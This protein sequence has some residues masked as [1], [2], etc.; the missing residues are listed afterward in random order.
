MNTSES[1][2]ERRTRERREAAQSAPA[3]A[4]NF[5]LRHLTG[6]RR[7]HE[8]RF[9]TDRVSVGRGKNNH[10]SF[11]A[12]KERSVSHR[13][14]E[15]RIEDSVAILYDIGSLNGTY[16][17]GRRIRR[18]PLADGD[19]IGLGRE[20]PRL[21]FSMHSGQTHPPVRP[22]DLPQPVIGATAQESQPI[23][24]ASLA[25]TRRPLLDRRRMIG[26]GLVVGIIIVFSSGFFF[27]HK[28]L[29]RIET[30]EGDPGEVAVGSRVP[31][32]GD[33]NRK[34]S[35]TG[36]RIGHA[37]AGVPAGPRGAVIRLFGAVLDAN[38]RIADHHQVGYGVIVEP[39]SVVTTHD[40]FERIR[41]WYDRPLLDTRAD[42]A[43]LA[44][45]GGAIEFSVHVE[46]FVK[47]PRAQERADHSNVVLLYLEEGK[48]L[49]RVMTAPPTS[50]G[51]RFFP[52]HEAAQA[53][54]VRQFKDQSGGRAAAQS[55]FLIQFASAGGGPPPP[56]GMPI[57]TR[58][59]VV[60]LSL[61]ADLSGWAVSSLAIRELLEHAKQA[62][63][64][65]ITSH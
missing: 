29:D 6:D 63:P 17:N 58:S 13:H 53:L 43:I 37:P 30:L 8:E 56:A 27:V 16:V 21:R 59:D 22:G 28:L 9:C 4:F 48:R 38:Q 12:E 3:S 11:D 15:V 36:N 2:V 50:D 10:C 35:E 26:L 5:S 19:E 57:F 24:L 49:A 20:G 7:G 32:A 46:S 44:A 65:L 25:G 60:G 62:T 47:H 33:G 34:A 1:E 23:E 18:A 64:E 39:G 45:P 40:V 14:C 55:A 41:A 42:K 51:L 52:P 54:E 61:G 31:N